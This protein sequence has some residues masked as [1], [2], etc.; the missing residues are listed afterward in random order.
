MT[1]KLTTL[2]S[3]SIAMTLSIIPMFLGTFPVF[4]NALSSEAGRT[5][6]AFPSLLL[7][8]TIAV[9]LG[10]LAAG[11]LVDRYGCRWVAILG[12]LIFGGCLASLSQMD[13]IGIAVYPLFVLLGVSGS[14]CG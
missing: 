3:S 12:I 1:R 14:F 6:A 8:A 5:A 10:G 13:R 4:L 9:A 11:W 7:L 2:V